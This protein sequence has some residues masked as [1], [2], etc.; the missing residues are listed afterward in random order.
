MTPFQQK[1][2]QAV[3][4]IPKGTVFSYKDVAHIIGHPGAA[5]AVGSALKKNTDPAVPCHRVIKSTGEP[6]GYNGLAG[7]TLSLLKKE[8]A[9]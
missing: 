5:R 1:V 4:Q 8:G 9:L 6:G 3:K 2:Y 7:K